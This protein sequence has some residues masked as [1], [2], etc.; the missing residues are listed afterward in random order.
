ME[1]KSGLSSGLTTADAQ[2]AICQGTYGGREWT[3]AQRDAACQRYEQLI[4]EKNN[5]NQPDV[6]LITG[7]V[8]G[9]ALVVAALAGYLVYRR[10]R[11]KSRRVTDKKR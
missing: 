8:L 6:A 3:P 4:N 11:T 7:V 5:V 10:K 1:S 9:A 2:H